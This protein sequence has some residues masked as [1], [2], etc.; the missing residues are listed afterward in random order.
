MISFWEY[1]YYRL[2]VAY[3]FD[4]RASGPLMVLLAINLGAVVSFNVKILALTGFSGFGSGFALLGILIYAVSLLI[5]TIT[6]YAYKEIRKNNLE[7]KVVEFSKE[8]KEEKRK[9]GKR[10]ATY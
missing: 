4:T 3:D 8:N 7:Q 5:A 2:L 9:N 10:I 6:V 1:I